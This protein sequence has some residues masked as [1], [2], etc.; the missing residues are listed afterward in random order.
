MS[1]ILIVGA[2]PAGNQTAHV[3]SRLGHSVTVLD[4]REVIGDKLCTG[5]VGQECAERYGVLPEFIYRSANSVRVLPPYSDPVAI[6]RPEIQAYVIDRVA[7]V[8][9]L[10][11]RARRAGA[12][13]RL[14]RRVTGIRVAP[15]GVTV[16]A[17]VP[18]GPESPT[19]DATEVYRARAVVIAAGFGSRLARDVGLEPPRT[20]AFAAQVPISGTD[21]DEVYVYA[22]RRMP[23]GFFGWVVPTQPGRALVGLLG[24]GRPNGALDVLVGGLR[25]DGIAVDAVGRRRTWGVPLRPVARSYAD[26]ALLVGD[27][28]GHVKPTTGGGIY[29]ALR[30]A[31][32]AAETL[33]RGLDRDDL[34]AGSLK[35]YEEG[36]KSLLG[37]EL[38]IGY[39]A[40]LLYERLD[41]AGVERVARAAASNG[42]LRGD[43]SFD[44]HSG[45][46]A[47]A[48]GSR[49]FGGLRSKLAT[50]GG[51]FAGT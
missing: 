44:W 47:R 11:E 35:R 34:S 8:A 24:R 36:W 43:V 51:G 20:H 21:V 22:G 38:R 27:V 33:H 14:R 4:A 23:K 29:Y 3:L 42:L 12:E 28:A 41:A 25:E 6:S 7:F 30:A 31:D 15:D 32:L 26:R 13:Y 16:S 17:Q 19:D 18:A 10:A 48:L 5:I 2:G 40:R 46:V 45:V 50:I 37:R 9:S 1:D 39:L 49:L